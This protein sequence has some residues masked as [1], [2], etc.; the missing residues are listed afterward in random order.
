MRCA[1]L[2]KGG[3]GKQ[4]QKVGSTQYLVFRIWVI[5]ARISNEI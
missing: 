5:F 2:G 1:F 4:H 3:D